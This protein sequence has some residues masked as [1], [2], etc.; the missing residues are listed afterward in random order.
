MCLVTL[1]LSRDEL[2]RPLLHKSLVKIESE[3]QKACTPSR[4]RNTSPPLGRLSVQSWAQANKRSAVSTNVVFVR[5][6]LSAFGSHSLQFLLRR[7]IR[8]TDIH[9]QAFLAN[10]DAVELANHLIADI[11]ILETGNLQLKPRKH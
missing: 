2:A 6:E 5:S 10:A 9:Q 1:S 4:G 11:S 7:S 8:I 3:P